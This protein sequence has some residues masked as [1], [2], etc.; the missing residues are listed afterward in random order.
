MNPKQR[1]NRLTR[2][3][4]VCLSLILCLG[5]LCPGFSCAAVAED[6]AFHIQTQED[7]RALA[8]NCRL[9]SWSQG[10]TVVL[11]NDLTLDETAEEFLPIPS[12]GGTLEGNNHKISGVLLDG[13][14][15]DAGLFDTLQDTAVVRHLTVVGQVTPSSG[16]TV[17]G[18]AGKNYGRLVDCTFEGT[19]QGDTAVG[20]LVGSN[21]ASGQIVSCRFR[22]TVTGEHYVGGIAGQNTGSLVEC[23]NSGD[24]NTTAVE[25]PA[26]FT[27]LS[28]L[29]TTESVPAGTD[30]GGV[31]GFSGG[32]IQSCR[33]TGNVGYEHMGYNV[34]GIVGRQSGILAGCKNTG[35]IQGRKDV[36]GIAGQLEPQVTLRYDED[37]LQR[38]G[39][40][41]ETLQG[42]VSQAAKDAE[43]SSDSVSGSIQTMLTEIESAK[44]AVHHLSTALTDWGND[45]LEQVNTVSARLAWVIDRS[46]TALASMSD[47]IESMKNASALLTQAAKEAEKAG[48]RGAEASANLRLAS[49]ELE[50]AAKSAED[51]V[52]HLQTALEQAEK[53]LTGETSEAALQE[54]LNELN[55]A[56][57]DAEK[58]KNSLSQAVSHAD[59]AIKSLESIGDPVSD[60]LDALTSASKYLHTAL[61]FLEDAADQM[62]SI[63]SG[64]ADKTPISFT[65][66]GSSITGR[67]DELDAA[68]SQVLSTAGELQDQLSSSS[69]ALLGDLRAINSQTGVIADLLQQGAADAA[70]SGA[71]DSFEDASDKEE[72]ETGAGR[73]GSSVNSGNVLGDVNVA[74]IVGSL[75]VEFDFDPE[76]DLTKD[77]TRSLDYQ[78]RTV[79]VVDGCINRGCVTAKKNDAGGIAGRMDLGAIRNCESYGSVES[80]GGD[81]VGG[82]AGS[83]RSVIR[84]CFVKCTLSGG[85]YIGGVTGTGGENSEVSGCYT[86]VDIT[87]AGRYSG[88]ISG[89]ETGEFSGN[90]Y[91]S[92]TLAGLGRI[93][94]AGK[95]EPIA[96]SALEQTDGVPQQMTQFT[97]RFL[98]EDE[99]IKSLSFSYGDSFG[100]EV[101]PAIPEKD[102]AYAAWDTDDLTN[103]HFDTTVTA[104]YTRYVLALSSEA[105]RESG[106]SVFLLDGNFDDEASLTV[107][108]VD[109]PET[110]NGRP[111]V[112]QWRLSCSDTS[113]ESYQVRYL[114]PEE[115][116]D[117]YTVFVRQDG[118]WQEAAC[119]VFGSYLVFSVPAAEAEIAVV[120]SGMG[121]LLWLAVGIGVLFVLGVVFLVGKKARGRKKKTA[122]K[123]SVGANGAQPI[124]AQ[125]N[126]AQLDGMRP[127]GARP[128][129][130]QADGKP[131]KKRKKRRMVLLAAAAVILVTAG[132]F[133]VRMLMTASDACAL[134]R[135][136]TESNGVMELSLDTEFAEELTHTELRIQKTETDGHIV[137]GISGDGLSLWYTGDTVILENGRAFAVSERYPDYSRLPEETVKL[138]QS[139][140][141]SMERAG[142]ETVYRL[143]AEGEQSKALLQ[144]L[145]PGQADVL[146]D[147]QKLNIE[148]TAADG[149]V[150]S[151]TFSAEGTLT[152]DAKTSYT[153]SAKL[154]PQKTET[155]DTLP[156]A[157]EETVRTGET[158][159]SA[160]L[161][162]D[163]F[164]LL[165][166]W[167]KLNQQES[168]S[169][170][171]RLEVEC[172]S[173]SFRN[174]MRYGQALADGQKIRCLRKD[175]LSVYFSNG[176]FCDQSG[177]LVAGE[178][179]EVSDGARL[180]AA[181]GRICENGEFVCADTG[182]DT[183]LYT[184]TMDEEGMWDTACA[185]APDIASMPVTMRS[186]SVQIL[187]KDGSLTEV[188]CS[189]TGGLDG[190]EESAPVTVEMKMTL[191]PDRSFEVPNAV[192]GRLLENGGTEDEQ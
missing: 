185:A 86:L 4:A 137:S 151:L 96:F 95:A 47:A 6:G 78:F 44:D 90:Y 60:S 39:T 180:L 35:T 176:V 116:A 175:G 105:V 192:K 146:P 181:L 104:E 45:N 144:L 85:D 21:E 166:A 26:E 100:S 65:P 106:R 118:K 179:N 22:G 67:A 88:A 188:S 191:T 130:V 73:I 18:L 127:D 189:C 102:G 55:D 138:F 69:D 117:G 139:H 124:G 164:R 13:E 15:A 49:K 29:R 23:E 75:S 83:A 111:A 50:E 114:S 57:T 125:P 42:L 5:A 109:T 10:K 112:E 148:L 182:N 129:E 156:E 165:T 61:S 25:V 149:D 113:Q 14:Q 33:N 132:A 119:S 122:S 58:A 8:E 133:A 98:V 136:L 24:V 59:R 131:V 70:D 82:V 115:T 34:G 128:D 177:T 81:Y 66:V 126:R 48:D 77:G 36:G 158:E 140:A 183:W 38:L 160:V 186:G 121:W 89:T 108:A 37:T 9:D 159:T 190:A 32:I 46:E 68:L 92:D 74:G 11:D 145:L 152:D 27:D 17:G 103:L 167:T 169:A 172:G 184:M 31:A 147:T 107:S 30:I 76:D 94:Y 19:V 16:D 64:L 28:L 63:A 3:T 142:E 43:S 84:G 155:P 150:V 161:S 187:V 52:T 123:P 168:F 79:A 2:M 41:L 20:G 62:T 163:L 110:V 171:L 153:L 157:V 154:T 173:I 53:L 174:E 91:V 40:E 93:S 101:F 56:K 120:P 143:T 71:S 170:D 135:S 141:F 54:I 51:C 80:T 12:F 134:L 1:K 162:D 72:G 87:E 7:L 97:L 178:E 99:E